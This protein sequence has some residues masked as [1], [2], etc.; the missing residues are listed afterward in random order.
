MD[1]RILVYDSF[2]FG[3]DIFI[4]TLYIDNIRGSEVCSFEYDKEYL[5]NKGYVVSIDPEIELVSGRQYCA[6]GMFGV[7]KDAC[8]DRWGRVLMQKRET[9]LSKEENRKAK[10]L[11]ESDYL[12]GVDDFTRVG[13][14]RF[15][16]QED[17]PYLAFDKDYSVPPWTTL[18]SLEEAVRNYEK[19]DDNNKWLNQLI[20]PGS[21]LGGAR[22]K[23]NVVDVE[24]NLWI[25]KFPSKY[26]DYDVCAFEKVTNDL[27]KLCK[28]DVPESKLEKFSKYG[29]TFLVK[30]FDRDGNRRIHF[31]SAMTLL[32][33]KDGDNDT[34]YLD[35]VDFIKERGS[36]CK[37][38]LI[39][40][41]KR[42][43]FNIAISNSDDHLR[44]H[45]FIYGKNGF[46]LSPLYDVN[47]T[48]YSDNLSLNVDE[49]NN[50]MSFD[51]LLSTCNQ[52]GINKEEGFN[53]IN[54]II[55][56]VNNNFET[57]CKNYDIS[58]NSIKTMSSCIR[59]W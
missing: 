2:G 6:D 1:K 13:G 20:K 22:P 44:N 17:G 11:L 15:K 40:L 33:K 36:N 18:R 27:A 46:R 23:A 25:A 31:E 58:R 35:I 54:E 53:Y 39:E 34:S 7:F 32:Q 55:S 16:T 26:D 24:G 50:E 10:K 41:Y 19:D 12:L 47:P 59:K 21:S 51:L 37:D 43:A 14:L 4:G 28:L 8:P 42:I 45:A 5:N 30:R 29:S 48:L 52:Y 57:I 9:I 3:N 49:Y 38:D 56:I